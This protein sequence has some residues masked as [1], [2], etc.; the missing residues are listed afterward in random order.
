MNNIKKV[1]WGIVLI[2]LGIIIGLNA[3]DITH[4]NIFFDG[5]WTFF[6]IIPSLIE[7]FDNKQE[8]KT[9]NLIGLIIGLVLL[10]AIRDIISF[11]IVGKLFIPFI[12]VAIGLSIVFNETIKNKVTAKVNEGKKNG[13]ENITATFAE[14]KVQKDNEEFSGANLDA[15]F[16][17][18]VLD[19]RQANIQ[20]EA[21]IKASAI[22]GGVE[23]ILPTNV[24]VKVKSTPIFGGVSNKCINNKE[25]QTIIYIDAFCMF[26]GADIK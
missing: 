4:I 21:V 15:V 24:N 26:G 2:A 14:Q 17:S 22:F 25:N 16:G 5:W 9:G 19:L 11:E 18:V 6:I 13:L 7:L 8:T 12:L 10:L 1:L 20:K 3:L 23:I